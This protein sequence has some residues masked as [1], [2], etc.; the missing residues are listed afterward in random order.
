MI[1]SFSTN[2]DQK[3]PLV[4]PLFQIIL[5]TLSSLIFSINL[6]NQ[7]NTWKQK[8]PIPVIETVNPITY[9]NFGG[10]A[11]QV[12]VGLYIEDFNIF[13]TVKNDFL[14]SGIVWFMFPIGAFAL[15]TLSQFSFARADILERSR[16][17]TLLFENYMVAQYKI[18]I[19]FKS[20]L[21]L[22]DF[23]LDNH[24]IVIELNHTVISPTEMLFESGLQFFQIKPSNIAGWEI[25][26]RQITQGYTKVILS[27]ENPTK[28]FYYPTVLFLVDTMRSG[29][30]YP[31][32]LFLPLL[33]IFFIILFAFSIQKEETRITLT[34]SGVTGILAYRF[35][36]A[37]LSPQVGY[38]MISDY[39]FFLFLGL[40]IMIF[41][42]NIVD[43]FYANFSRFIKNS[44]V[45]FF[46][47]I[48]NATIMYLFYR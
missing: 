40:S 47:L 45:I 16:P 38:F 36:I 11:Y 43:I 23:P 15:D 32:T 27:E 17:I 44:F 20:P 42:V 33:M 46:H 37:N 29:T 21:F 12:K 1:S 34:A 9:K 24:R 6:Y 35:V 13:D 31:L 30:Q 48:T 8:D 14:L 5:I 4:S 10:F 22:H 28:E 18:K 25:V 7:I 41:L 39:C 3:N 19:R 26:D 2:K